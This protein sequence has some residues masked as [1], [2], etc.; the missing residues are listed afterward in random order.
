MSSGLARS[1]F[2]NSASDSW[3]LRPLGGSLVLLTDITVSRQGNGASVQSLGGR[4][5]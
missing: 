2:S 5:R 4:G 3:S 1:F